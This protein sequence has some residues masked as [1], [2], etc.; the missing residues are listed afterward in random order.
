MK[1]VHGPNA[2]AVADFEQALEFETFRGLAQHGAAD[3]K[4][5]GH[6]TFG[7]QFAAA[8]LDLVTQLAC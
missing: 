1:P 5:L 7:R 8:R 3:S 4:T 2:A 6:E